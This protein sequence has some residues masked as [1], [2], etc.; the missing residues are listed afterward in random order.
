VSP[1]ENKKEPS[2]QT[3]IADEFVL[4]YA[5]LISDPGLKPSEL[6]DYV[7]KFA[8]DHCIL[9][10][11]IYLLNPVILMQATVRNLPRSALH[12]ADVMLAKMENDW[13][14]NKVDDRVY[15]LCK[16]SVEEQRRQILSVLQ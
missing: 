7:E 3:N 1:V 16:V 8:I 4:E 6:G 15:L 14:N 2:I 9:P 11:K 13:A 12:I 10:P 5:R